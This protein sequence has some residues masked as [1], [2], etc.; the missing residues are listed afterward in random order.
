MAPDARLGYAVIMRRP[1]LLILW[2]ISDLL[3]FTGACVFAYFLRTGWVLSTEF[4]L[5]RFV[6]ATLLAAPVWL[7]TLIVTRTF[8]L[9]RRQAS[10][11][12]VIYMLYAGIMASALLAV[13]Y[14]FLYKDI[15]SRLLL[16]E[17]GALST[18]AV[19]LWHMFFGYLMRRSLSGGTTYPTLV[20][21]VTRES[22]VLIEGLRR[23]HHPLK[24]VAILDGRGVKDKEIAGVPV[25]GKLNKLED[26]LR[27]HRITHLIQA[28]DLEQS[29]NL[30]SACR[31]HG[32]TYMLLPSVL[33]M[34]ERDERIESL[35][36]HP[37]TVVSPKQSGWMW[38]FR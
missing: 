28:S 25:L 34:V 4:P 7:G 19:F 1:L 30:L 10:V 5:E 20:V 23:S 32:I 21:G 11:R 26:V 33:G 36:G 29:I 3:V 6:T 9:T 18:L 35:E 27:D 38:F 31:A 15:F 2:L 16:V 17:A 14:F 22:R 24:P 12:N 8:A 13:I 37:V